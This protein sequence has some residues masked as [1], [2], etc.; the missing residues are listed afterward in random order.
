MSCVYD[1]ETDGIYL[2]VSELASYVC[3]GGDIQGRFLP[4]NKNGGAIISHKLHTKRPNIVDAYTFT[5]LLG[6]LKIILYTYPEFVREDSHGY[7]IESVY[8]VPYGL[9][10]L[11][12]GAL[13]ISLKESLLA[14]YIM[15]EKSKQQS[16]EITASFFREGTDESREY[17]R[18]AQRD[19]LLSEFEGAILKI[20]P[21]LKIIKERSTDVISELHSLR[22]PFKEGAREGQKEFIIE[23]FKAIH[24]HKRLV[25]EAP[26]GTGKTM[27]SLYPSLKSLGEG[28]ADKIFYFTGKTTTAL[29]ALNA[30]DIMRDQIPSLRAIHLSS[31][32]KCCV[33]FPPF[34]RRKCEPRYCHVT[35]GYFD[36]I[37][38]ALLELLENYKTYTKDV[39]DEIAAKH[40][41]CAYELS[42]EL[43]EW[44][45]LIVCDYNYL[46][47]LNAYL[48]RYFEGYDGCEKIFLIDEAHNLP[49][50]AREM[51]SV[52][53]KREDFVAIYGRYSNDKYIGEPLANILNR[54][55]Y[56]HE[57]AM[58]EKQEIEGEV[59]GFYINS[60]LPEDICEPFLEL[61]TGIKKLFSRD[62]DDD[63][64]H[65]M[66]MNL[67]KLLAVSDIF[68][69]RF[70]LYIEAIGENVTVR[71]LCLDPS[72][73]LNEGLKKGCASILFSAT[74]T[75]L[76]YYA[77]ILGCEKTKTLTLKSPFD[78]N[79]LCLVGVNNV[80]TRYEDRK[81]SAGT[82]ANIIRAAIEGKQGNYIVYFP[83]YQYLTE[84]LEIFE[85]KYPKI[86]VTC[87][88]KSMSEK[89]KK[90][91]LDSF[92]LKK[93]GTLVGFCVL[94]GSFSEGIDLRGERLIGAIIVGVGL[95]TI[96]SELNIIKEYYD[97]TRE[98]GYSYA[99]TYPGLIKVMQAAG[100]VI[101]SED[102]KGVVFLVDDRFA[103]PEYHALFPEYWKHIKYIDNAKGLLSEVTEFWKK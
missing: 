18:T 34:K 79:K 78:K 55:D 65:A 35:R 23:S 16:V 60:T 94:G 45:E 99:Y 53:L 14:A 27:A 33:S 21:L 50:R 39:I 68:D 102:E 24:A 81:K 71:L 66:Y 72:Y 10:G 41:V 91:F 22:F 101:R 26:T 37:N 47:D 59:C 100:R 62:V 83:S 20:A 75:P 63:E 30:V 32:E 82:V 96:S 25:A 2:S 70:T 57:L 7:R 74:L 54:F 61:M 8:T 36:K 46:F 3:R 95:P 88:K 76:E 43:S 12:N 56:Y 28:Y 29:S 31:K 11:D 38:D 6:G 51:Y 13:E 67:K 93:D 19:E 73:M 64:L 84:V 44:C 17:S 89:A 85:K 92:D 48:H 77:D 86:N 5:T 9:D 103:T 98:N 42:L 69:K 49:D 97:K 4:G 40:G 80:S 1:K 90:E 58:A 52:T 87:Q 15:C